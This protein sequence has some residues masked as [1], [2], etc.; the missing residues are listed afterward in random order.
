MK[1]IVLFLTVSVVL[2]H[3]LRGQDTLRVSLTQV[4]DI[5][6]S[7]SP[8]IKIADKEIARVDYS[9]RSAWYALLPSVEATGQYSKFLVPAQMSMF[10]QVMDSPTDFN[11]TAGLSLSLPLF[12]PAL[13][14]TIQLSTVE[15][16]AAAEKAN[17]SR[18]ALRN[19]VTKAYYNVLVVRDSYGVLLD[20]YEMAR[21]NYDIAKKGYEVG[22]KSAYD[23]ISAEVQMN[24]LLPNLLQAENGITQA[25]MLLKILMGLDVNIPLKVEGTLADFE[26]EIV[27]MNSL[28]DY[29]LVHNSDLKQM[30]ISRTQIQ[31]SLQLQR[32]Q[33]MPMLSAFGQ[34]GYNGT[35]NNAI[36]INFGQMPIQTNDRLEWFTQGLVVGVRLHVPI[37]GILTNVPKEKQLR[38]QAQ[39][40]E[41]QQEQ[42]E[43][44]LHL[45]V[46]AALDKMNKSVRQVNAARKSVELSQKAY[47]ISSKR[48]ENGSGTMLEL[49]NSALAITQSGLSYHQAISDYFV[50]KSELE[51]LLGKQL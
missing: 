43:K 10:G 47:D 13:W 12:A 50:A 36:T 35:R 25:S 51:K 7:E 44:N 34:Y 31:K 48:Y 49:Q 14:K 30:E 21:Q 40:L 38:I 39:Q 5:A 8:T 41:M 17:A 32:T 33:R 3:S 11:A 22:T 46:I 20:G 1:K 4:L 29:S 42:L 23:Y 28:A 19:E 2:L 6:L 24:N 26:K 18:I 16:Q 27:E 45:Q 9:K 37:T 15:M